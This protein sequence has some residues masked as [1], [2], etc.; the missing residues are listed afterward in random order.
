LL[1]GARREWCARITARR[2]GCNT[3]NSKG[4]ANKAFEEVVRFGLG[5]KSLGKFG[6]DEITTMSELCGDLELE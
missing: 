3:T 5:I 1:E 6:F 4:S 2:T